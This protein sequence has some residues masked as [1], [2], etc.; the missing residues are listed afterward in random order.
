MRRR[1]KEITARTVIETILERARVCRIGLCDRGTPYVVPVCFRYKDGCLYFH[2]A[3]AGR[4]IGILRQNDRVC[5]E[6]D[7]DVQL[8]PGDSP[9][10]WSVRY[11]SVIGFGRA[12]FVDDVQE[13]AEGLNIIMEHYAGRHF[14][15]PEEALAEVAIIKVQV[16]TMTGKRS[17]LHLPAAAGVDHNPHASRTDPEGSS[18]RSP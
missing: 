13:K 5:F 17:K 6:A 7:I 18:R 8:L 1:E 14:E 9:C 4:K 11:V 12:S 10:Q 3:K 16:D 15:Y 2:S